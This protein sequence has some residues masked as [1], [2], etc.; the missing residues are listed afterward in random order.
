MAIPWAD[1][2]R[3]RHDQT[4][5]GRDHA[6][7]LAMITSITLLH[8]HQRPWKTRVVG[9]EE[10]AYLEATPEDAQLANRLMSQVMGQS[11]GRLRGNGRRRRANPLRSL[12]RRCS[13]AQDDA[14][15]G[16]RGEGGGSE[17]GGRQC[18]R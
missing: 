13:R 9:S 3:F 16:E 11:P 15:G 1:Q 10:V 14:V 12:G 17:G 2:F 18:G 5:M 7:Y 4:G 8:Q 6:K